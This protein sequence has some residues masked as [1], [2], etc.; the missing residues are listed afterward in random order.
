M[1]LGSMYVFIVGSNAGQALT[2]LLLFSSWVPTPF[3]CFPLSP[4]PTRI[5]VPSRLKRALLGTHSRKRCVMKQWQKT[6]FI[7][8]LHEVVTRDPIN[9]VSRESWLQEENLLSTGQLTVSNLSRDTRIKNWPL[10]WFSS[11]QPENWQVNVSRWAK[12]FCLSGWPTFQFFIKSPYHAS[13]QHS[14][15]GSIENTPKTAFLKIDVQF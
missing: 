6:R 10:R 8:M 7:R 14:T 1:L 15:V 2:C 11:F 9:M 3:A 13:Y 5:C 4:P 12:T